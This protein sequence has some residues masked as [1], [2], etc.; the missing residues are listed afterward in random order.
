MLNSKNSSNDNVTFVSLYS[1]CGGMDLG[2]LQAGMKCIKSLDY[3]VDAIKTLLHNLKVNAE[4][5]DLTNY[6]SSLIDLISTADILIAGPPCQGFSTAGKNNPF[7]ER[8]DHLVNVARIAG[9]AKPKV[10]LI[11]NVKGILSPKNAIHL[12]KAKE[13]LQGAGYT[14]SMGIHDASDYGVAQSRKRVFI[15]ATKTNSPISLS[16][17]CEERVN[18]ADVLSNLDGND[19]C[20]KFIQVD[21]LEYRIAERI[22]PGHK[23][24]NVRRS[25]TSLHTWEIP[26]VFGAVNEKEVS[27]LETI[28]KLRRQK[29]R[30]P[31]GDADPVSI[32]LLLQ[33]FGP[34]IHALILSLLEKKYLRQSDGFVDVT[35]TFNGKYWRLKWD[36]ISPTVH[37]RFGQ[38]RYFLHPNENRGFTVREAATI[39]SFPNEFE[40][41]GTENSKFRMIGNA[42]P[43]KLAKAIALDIKK[44]WRTL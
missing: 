14:L 20:K 28:V 23:L 1:G 34:E 15:L 21:S 11:E 9:R 41:L 29:R 4:I 22:M 17:I 13:I 3:D 42:V 32:E 44:I 31:T 2:F 25:R 36:D 26:E 5:C 38:P 24:S 7:D 30:R 10:V 8:N 37:T 39:Q 12:E 35:N 33:L 16:L 27:L 19:N 18:L 40:F 43:P 6:D